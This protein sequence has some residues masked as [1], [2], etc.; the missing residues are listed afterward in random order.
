MH[1]SATSEITD[2]CDEPSKG[3]SDEKMAMHSNCSQGNG[4]ENNKIAR[5]YQASANKTESA[6]TEGASVCAELQGSGT[7]VVDLPFKSDDSLPDA[8]PDLN[9]QNQQGQV[10]PLGEDPD[11]ESAQG[12]PHDDH[13]QECSQSDN[14]P[15]S[16][17]YSSHQPYSSCSSHSTG[18]GKLCACG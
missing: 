4:N 3:C 12:E 6:K 9:D 14:L 17:D 11:D 16:S 10:L 2:K 8:Q 13:H 1:K 7:G 15:G 18:D 5:S